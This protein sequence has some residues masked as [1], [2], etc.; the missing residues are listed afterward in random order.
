MLQ[1]AMQPARMADRRSATSVPHGTLTVGSILAAS[2]AFMLVCQSQQLHQRPDVASLG[3]CCR[4][5]ERHS[6]I[7]E[8]E[9]AS[10][11]APRLQLALYPL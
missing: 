5:G 1:H 7:V 8:A 6:P 3:L 10:A 11:A 4:M 9:R 2:C